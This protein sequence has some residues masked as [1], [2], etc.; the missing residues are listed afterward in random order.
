MGKAVQLAGCHFAT[1]RAS[2]TCRSRF[3]V[4]AV[5][6]SSTRSRQLRR[7][8]FTNSFT[9]C[10]ADAGPRHA[11][12]FDR[13]NRLRCMANAKRLRPL[14]RVAVTAVVLMMAVMADLFA[15]EPT[16]RAVDAK[17]IRV[18]TSNLI[19]DHHYGW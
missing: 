10:V 16:A 12:G 8:S 5:T 13:G 3:V 15:F 9:K 18:A 2:Q 6:A 14:T 17:A 7:V 4:Q 11:S 19:I 1:F